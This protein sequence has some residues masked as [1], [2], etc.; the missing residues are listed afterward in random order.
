MFV[1]RLSQA[2]AP[3][4]GSAGR[5]PTLHRTPLN[6]PCSKHMM[7]PVAAMKDGMILFFYY[8]FTCPSY[9]FMALMS[10]LY[11]SSCDNSIFR[12]PNDITITHSM[13]QLSSPLELCSVVLG[14]SVRFLLPSMPNPQQSLKTDVFLS[15]LSPLTDQL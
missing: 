9:F 3:G 11:E 6:L 1:R 13:S 14:R 4:G 12:V 8:S 5:A 7:F 10:N 15:G 2:A